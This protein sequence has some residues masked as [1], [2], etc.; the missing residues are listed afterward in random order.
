MAASGGR[1]LD[2]NGNVPPL[3]DTIDLPISSWTNR[4]GAAELGRV[5][6][7]PN[8]DPI[9]R[10]FL[11][12]RAPRILVP[13]ETAHDADQFE[14]ALPAKQPLIGE[15]RAYASPILHAQK[16]LM[17]AFGTKRTS[18]VTAAMSAYGSKADVPTLPINVG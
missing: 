17:S 15:E 9:V 3:G 18:I 16:I 8:F 1:E 11:Y 13:R 12:A 6:T 2:G 14:L 7:D 4:I 5:G 10:A